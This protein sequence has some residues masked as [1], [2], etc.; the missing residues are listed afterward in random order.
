MPPAVGGLGHS[1]GQE[2]FNDYV[3]NVVLDLGNVAEKVSFQINDED[4]QMF[5][6]LGGENMN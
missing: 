2:D 4:K 3:T 6:R 5:R 1:M